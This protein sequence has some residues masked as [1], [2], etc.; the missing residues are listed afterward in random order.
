MLRLIVICCFCGTASPLW[1]QAD[2][3]LSSFSATVHEASVILS[4]TINA[5]STCNGIAVE[6]STD[7]IAYQEIGN[8]A[9]VCGSADQSITY[10]FQDHRPALNQSNHYRL[11]LGSLGYTSARQ[12][13][14]VDFSANKIQVRPNP[15]STSF[16]IVIDNPWSQE[17]IGS[18]HDRLGNI[19][20]EFTTRESILFID[21]SM[22]PVGVY[23]FSVINED[24]LT[25]HSKLVVYR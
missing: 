9:G 3:A 7:G 17:L 25:F 8:I 19:I 6:R 2:A 1:A 4:W 18:L 16:Q 14:V 24:G 20:S 15:G 23:L 5:G 11:E 22:L 21:A 10:T 13:E 12:V